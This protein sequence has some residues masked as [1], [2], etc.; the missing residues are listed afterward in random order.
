MLNKF[1]REGVFNQDFGYLSLFFILV[2]GLHLPNL[3]FRLPS[4]DLPLVADLA[5][6]FHPGKLFFRQCYTSGHFPLWNPYDLCGTPFLA[7]PHLGALYPPGLLYL[8]SFPV[9]TTLSIFLHLLLAGFLAYWLF[10]ALGLSPPVAFIAGLSYSLSGLVFRYVNFIPSLHT[11]AWLPLLFLAGFKLGK[12]LRIRWLLLF[13][14]GFGFSYLGGDTETLLYVL[15]LLAWWIL[16]LP[17]SNQK[18][19]IVLMILAFGFCFLITSAQFLPTLEFFSKSLRGASEFAPRMDTPLR[20]L[21]LALLY[22]LYLLFIVALPSSAV[23]GGFKSI[24]IYL[25]FLIFLGF[26]I[27]LRGRNNRLSRRLVYFFGFL[28]LY[29]LIFAL[30]FLKGLL[31]PLPIFGKL[32]NLNSI[33]PAAEIGFLIIAG[34]GLQEFLDQKHPGWNRAAKYFF[35]VYGLIVLAV[36]LKPNP[37]AVFRITLGLA[38]LCYPFWAKRIQPAFGLV[39]LAILDIFGLALF[40]LPRHSYDNFQYH[41]E[42]VSRL[43]RT[44]L[45]GRYLIVSSPGLDQQFPFSAGIKLKA[46][47]IDS[48]IRAPVWNYARLIQT[49]FPGIFQQEDGKIIFYDMTRFRDS[50]QLN[51]NRMDLLDLVNLRWVISRVPVP[52]LERQGRYRLVSAQPLYF[53]ENQNPF[54]RAFLFHQIVKADSDQEGFD[55]MAKQSFNLREKLLMMSPEAPELNGRGSAEPEFISLF[56]PSPDQLSLTFTARAPGYLFLSETYFPGWRAFL[57]EKEARIWRADYAFR[58]IDVGPGFHNLELVYQPVS[59]RIGIW[60]SLATGLNLLLLIGSLIFRRKRNTKVEG[61]G[62]ERKK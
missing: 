9:A 46:D 4:L 23:S 5:D 58:A 59:F 16:I 48:I 17:A 56:R 51:E 35:P 10:R 2:L 55:L 44:E 34:F 22:G 54:P 1:K 61:G 3:I 47:T 37:A 31:S 40:Y 11:Q 57:D 27:G 19:L 6:L 38:L 42:L 28:F 43:S 12:E 52:I 24:P 32:L 20:A 25:G 53:Y 60:V 15:F 7:F 45:K 49:A 36:S 8:L 21:P 13:I 41:P 39:M 50:S 30:P 14:F 33:L 26:W 29:A 62:N 18:A